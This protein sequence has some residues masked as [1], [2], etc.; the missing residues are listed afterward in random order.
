[1]L[2]MKKTEPS[3]ILLQSKLSD[4]GELIVVEGRNDIP[5]AISRLFFINEK[6]AVK[7]GQH[8]H[9]QCTQALICLRGT[10][11]V[12]CQIGT[13]S[14]KWLLDSSDQCLIIPPMVWASQQYVYPDSTLLVLCDRPYEEADYIRD[15]DD[16]ILRTT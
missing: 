16:Y 7:R 2:T 4:T 14:G 5:F 10:I 13:D 3:K 11:E 12:T 15:F 6:S 1:M 9:I 8:A